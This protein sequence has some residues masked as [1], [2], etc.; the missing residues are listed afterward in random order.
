M[1]WGALLGT[2]LAAWLWFRSWYE[3][4]AKILQPIIEDIEARA[5]DGVI[6]KADRKAVALRAVANL[7][8][9]KKIKLNFL[10]RIFVAKVID[11]LAEKLP[12]F[13]LSKDAQ[14]LVQKSI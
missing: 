9:E 10:E 14:A 2:G 5:R 8:A 12:D 3:K 1:E 6:D 13:T 4:L 7:L 11:S